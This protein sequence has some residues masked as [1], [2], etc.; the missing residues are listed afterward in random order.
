MLVLVRKDGS[1]TAY[2]N[3]ISVTALA[4]SRR[5]LKKGEPV[6]VRDI[7]DVERLTLPGVSVPDDVGVVL[8]LSVRWRKG[9][10]FDFGPILPEGP[11]P[12]TYDLEK[13]CGQYYAYL[14]FQ[15]LFKLAE[16]EWAS[17]FSQGWFPFIHLGQPLLTKMLEHIRNGWNVDELL[18][19]FR[20]DVKALIRAEDA[21]WRDKPSMKDH[22][23]LLERAA[24]RY[25]DEDFISA[26][27][28]LYPRIEGI[29][30]SYHLESGRTESPTSKILTESIVA[31]G[32]ERRHDCSFLLPDRFK[33]YLKDVYFAG[34]EPGK[35][36]PMSRPSVAHGVASATDFSEKAA[37][38]G[39]FTVHQ[40]VLFAE[41]GTRKQDEPVQ[42]TF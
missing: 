16:E 14:L 40:I 21:I 31:Q 17:L 19:E 23:P 33:K 41:S 13:L 6:Y 5:S 29:M 35:R 8:L 1:A 39:W 36:A 24:E 18:P 9:L 11:G 3:E 34:F 42:R 2:I 22:A 7:L 38:I 10:Y 28:I 4:R 37:T 12:R 20:V 32:A 26:A 30:R 15:N 27:S 25:L